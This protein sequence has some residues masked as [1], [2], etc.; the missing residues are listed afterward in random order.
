[1]TNH[2]EDFLRGVIDTGDL[3]Y[4]LSIIIFALFL[5]TRFLESRR[6]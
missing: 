3:V 4:Y 6:W 2:F 1:M 5:A